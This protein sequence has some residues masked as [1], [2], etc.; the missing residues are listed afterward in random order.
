[1]ELFFFP[2]SIMEVEISHCC[3]FEKKKS[4]ID[5]KLD[6]PVYVLPFSFNLW[7]FLNLV[8]KHFFPGSTSIELV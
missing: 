4:L 1:M 5:M 2:H 7:K 6:F 3:Y 8:L